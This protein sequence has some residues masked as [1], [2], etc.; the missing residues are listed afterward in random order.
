MPQGT[1]AN[2]TDILKVGKVIAVGEKV[3]GINAGCKVYYNKHAITKVPE[4]PELI[5][6]RYED[7]YLVEE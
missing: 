1:S 4:H 2:A 3:E 7:T 5:V 6:V